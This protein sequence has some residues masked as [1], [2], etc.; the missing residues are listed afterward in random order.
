MKKNAQPLFFFKKVIKKA[1]NTA[2]EESTII[3]S[4]YYIAGVSCLGREK[5]KWMAQVAYAGYA[6]LAMDTTLTKIR[7]KGSLIH[8]F[9][10][11]VKN[12]L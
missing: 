5:F 1:I 7:N 12:T 3:W 2:R 11:R 10:I 4:N 9:L 6:F 8:Y